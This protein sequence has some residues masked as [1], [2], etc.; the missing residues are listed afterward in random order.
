MDE[1]LFNTIAIHNNLEIK[2]VPELSPIV[3]RHNW[4]LSDISADKL[5]HPIKNIRIQYH[6]RR[7][8]VN[9]TGT[10]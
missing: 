9:V 7:K 10:S 1:A 5:Y 4:T 2:A 6:Y 3:Y 8:L